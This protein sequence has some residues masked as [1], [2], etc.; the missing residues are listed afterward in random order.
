MCNGIVDTPRVL[1]TLRAFSATRT[2]RGLLFLMAC[3]GPAGPRAAKAS[4]GP[5][6][7]RSRDTTP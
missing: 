2:H 3:C 7:T 1:V 4:Y 5:V 6:N